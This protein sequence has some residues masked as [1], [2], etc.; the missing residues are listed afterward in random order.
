MRSDS[1]RTR[2]RGP[3]VLIGLGLLILVGTLLWTGLPLLSSDP[4]PLAVPPKVAD[5][6]L[7]AHLFGPEAADEIRRLHRRGFPMTGAA[8]AV[9]GNREAT[10]W[11]A[12]TWG[13]WGARLM[14][15]RMT[16]AIARSDTPFTPVGQRQLQGVTVYELT[17]M[18]Q[19]HFYFQIGD[20]IYWLA[21]VP[22]RAEQGVRDLLDFALSPDPLTS[23]PVELS[24][25]GR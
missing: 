13:T 5:F 3:Y 9:Y 20:R 23:A 24:D 14:N 16:Q 10:L 11:V 6:P 17:G 7:R 21:V 2:S 19:A 25:Q 1:I 18:G 4:I 8:V 15:F 22:E 12:R